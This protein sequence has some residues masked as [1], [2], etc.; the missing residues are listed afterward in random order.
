MPF[1]LSITSWMNQAYNWCNGLNHELILL[2]LEMVRLSQ[3]FLC[4]A[5]PVTGTWIIQWIW[6]I[7][8]TKQRCS[9]SYSVALPRKW[10]ARL[11]RDYVTSQYP[12]EISFPS[13]KARRAEPLPKSCCL[14]TSP[15]RLYTSSCFSHMQNGLYSP[16]L[17]YKCHSHRYCFL[18]GFSSLSTSISAPRDFLVRFVLL[19]YEI[20]SPCCPW[21]SL[22][23]ISP[24]IVASL[25]FQQDLWLGL[26]RHLVCGVLT[27][28]TSPEDRILGHWPPSLDAILRDVNVKVAGTLS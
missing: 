9:L 24:V 6:W 8:S 11:W 21:T 15:R 2:R 20:S 13:T 23:L 18:L 7:L 22:I 3:A 27:L 14:T 1:T 5:K 28:S 12:F 17:P 10:V 19:S 4:C 16:R 26:L 25:P